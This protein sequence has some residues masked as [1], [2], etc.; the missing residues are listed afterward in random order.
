MEWSLV[1]PELKEN[2]LKAG[3]EEGCISFDD[4]N[5]LLPDD[6]KD[7]NEIESIFNFLGAHS[8][9]IVTVEKSGE[10][11]TLS[12][13]VW[14]KTDDS[15]LEGG[16]E[17]DIILA[18]DDSHEAEE[19]TT[20]YLREMGRFDLLTPEEEA[21]YSKTIRQGFEA[22]ISAIRGDNSGVKEVQILRE[23]IDLWEKRDPT[24]KPKKQQLNFMRYTVLSAAK[25]YPEIRE[26]F[27][28]QAKLEAYSRSIEVA[29]DTMIRAN[30][31]LVVSIAKRY[32]H[33]GLTLADLIQEGNLGLMRAVFR[34]DYTKGNKFS[35]YASWWIRQAIT[36]AILDKTR[37]IRL[38]V[39]FLELRSQFFKAFYALFKELGREPT[40]LEISKAT[41]LPM[42][43]ILSILEA[44]REPISLET[45]VGD[46][47]STLG[48]FL[49]NQESQS[50]YD[51][52]QTRELSGRVN[53]ILE[54]LSEREEKII[55]LRFGIGEKAEY[56]LEEIGK[57][58]NV[59][60][61]RIRQIEKKALNRL[62]HSS[63]RDK[64][65][66][67]ID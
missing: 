9:E 58:F 24:L 31:R 2:L 46:D 32:M 41:N 8:I 25:K 61:E 52:V 42:D 45:P 47:D 20:T 7:P 59:S 4:L 49:E 55:R 16:Q 5:E 33:Q 48:D 11:R 10:K 66:F 18:D 50:P 43:K 29:K 38:P 62:R 6:I 22:I 51:A 14:E 26:L 12:G 65:K 44:S 63:R 35:T 13:E 1:L 40:P 36:R 54:T 3:K 56:T 53:D 64:L 37:T 19:T 28:L 39:H 60:R 17:E 15:V 57:L 27:E 23:R 67:F 30:L 34:F 21:K